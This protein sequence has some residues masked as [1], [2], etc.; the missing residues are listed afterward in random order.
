MPEYHGTCLCKAVQVSVQVEKPELGICHCDTCRKWCSAPFMAFAAQDINLEPKDK[1]SQY[2][3]SNIAK[4]SFCKICGTTLSFFYDDMKQK[5]VNP[6][7]LKD[8]QNITTGV[9]V[10]YD[11][12]PSCY[13]FDS[14]AQKYTEAE[15]MAFVNL[16]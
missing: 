6:W 11:N 5:F 9:E 2:A 3:S 13:S 15:T 10:C 14:K 1:V 4:R 7:I 8:V 12:K 16:S